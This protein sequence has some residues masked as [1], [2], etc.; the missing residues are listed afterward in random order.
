MNGIRSLAPTMHALWQRHEVLANDLANASTPGFKMDD[1]AWVAPPGSGADAVAKPVPWTSFLA[2][3]ITPTGRAL[4]VALDG[5]GFLV[6]ETPAGPR[7]TRGGPLSVS[8]DG[9]LV[10]GSGAPVLGASGPI[11]VG[12]DAG[13]VTIAASGDVLVGG[14]KVDTLRVVE[15]AGTPPLVKD[16]GGRFAPADGAPA[17]SPAKA[18]TV[19]GGALEASNVNPVSVMVGMIDV[20]RRY[21]TAQK[22]IQAEDETV[23]RAGEIGKV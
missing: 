5:R 1:V 20:L 9:V 15:F 7:Y 19:V 8:P 11:T 4:D 16:G 14:R 21:E 23:R 2:G 22:L 17:P 12:R 3:A 13:G 10:T 6:T 18:T